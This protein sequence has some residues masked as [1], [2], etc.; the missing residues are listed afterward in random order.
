MGLL[1][2]KMSENDL[3]EVTAIERRAFTD[4]WSKRAFQ[5]DL[6]S[7][8]AKPIVARFENH[9]AGYACLYLAADEMMIGNIA[10]SPDFQQR[11]IGSKMMEYI[12]DLA[13]NQSISQIALEVRE[14]NQA[15][16]S[17]YL[18][19]GFEITGRRKYYYRNPTEDALMM[20]KGI[21]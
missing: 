3:E 6:K 18:R 20:I 4:P 16:R 15:A 7:D 14:S 5:Y 9:I 1:I 19:F 10:V 13:V 21:K 2:E 11:G 8:Y 17:L 12:V